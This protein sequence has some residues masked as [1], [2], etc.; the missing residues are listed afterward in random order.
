M[1]GIEGAGIALNRYISAPGKCR[2]CER[3][4]SRP[5]RDQSNLQSVIHSLQSVVSPSP[6]SIAPV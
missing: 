2:V 1:A 6:T 4:T 5:K 3:S